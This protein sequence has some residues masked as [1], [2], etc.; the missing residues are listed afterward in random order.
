VSTLACRDCGFDGSRW[1]DD[2]IER[3]L[4]HTDDLIGYVLDGAGDSPIADSR[5]RPVGI[6]DN[7]MVAAHAL[8]HRLH[9]L[10]Q[11]RRDVETFEPMV[12]LVESLQASGGGVPKVS[13]ESA[14]VGPAGVIG[15]VQRNRRHHGRPWQA[16]CLYSTELIGALQDEGHPIVAGA[17]GENI[18]V[19]GIDWARLRGG[20]TITIG[21][22]VLRTTSPAAPCSNIGDCF[23]GRNWNRID[24]AE[25][26]G[27]A[28]WY[29]SVL[30]GGAVVHGDSVVVTA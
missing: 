18:T 24:H 3:T 19:S 13:I 11:L 30:R 9:E 12:G 14:E 1:S 6:G 15:D 25:R 4:A 29:A 27:W 22:V 8:M 16:I 28:R 23:T 2:D 7:S 17:I 5:T 20:L 21:D 26:P 10:A